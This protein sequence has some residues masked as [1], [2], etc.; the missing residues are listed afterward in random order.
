MTIPKKS[1]ASKTVTKTVTKAPKAES[2][3]NPSQAETASLTKLSR[4]GFPIVAIG[5]SAGGLEAFEIFFDAMPSN[6]GIGFILVAHLDPTH[7][8]LL[9]EL[10]Q[11]HTKMEVRQIQDGMKVLPDNVYVIPPNRDLTILNGSLQLM[12][13]T[14]PRGVNLPID[15]FFRSLAKDQ[16]PNATCI[17][18]SGTGTD[19][20]LGLRAIKGEVGMAMIQSEESAKYDG[21]PRSAISTGLADYILRPEEM[22]SHLIKYTRHVSLKSVPIIS[23][24][25]DKGANALQKIYI[26]LRE[27]T[28][29]DFS[30]YKKNTICRRI[31]R[32][33]SVH[34][35]DDIADYARYLQKS[36]RET[37][38]LFKELLIGVTNFFRDA[39]GFEALL[40]KHLM[41]LLQEKPENYTI[42]VW[43]PGCSSGEEAYSIAIILQ[44]CM[45]KLKSHFRVQIFGTDIDEDSIN[46]ARTGLYPESILADVSPE[47]LKR[48]FTEEKNG[49]YR[50][51]KSIREMLVFATQN[52]I[53]D[54]PFTKLDFLSCRNLLIYLGPELQQRLLPVF[55]YSLKNEGILFLGSSETVGKFT[56]LFVTLDQKWKIFKRKA[57]GELSYPSLTFPIIH[58]KNEMIYTPIPESVRK[59][60]AVSAL[61]LVETILQESNTPPCVIIDDSCNVVY[62]HGRTGRF[63]EPPEGKIS[64]NILEMARLGLKTDLAAA[65]RKVAVHKQE[66]ACRGLRIEGNDGG[67]YLNLSVK[68]IFEQSVMRGLMMVVFEETSK[69]TKKDQVKPL[70]R[71]I[72]D[73]KS[74]ETLKRELRHIKETLQTTIEEL[75]TSNEELKS[76]NEELQSTNE[77]LQSTNEEM[78]TS[79]EELQ[80]LNEESSTV[81]AELQRRIDELSETNDDMK[82]LLDRTEIA[83]LFLDT[84]LR[85][86]RFTPKTTEIIPLAGTDSGRP[87]MDFATSL[88]DANL[89][90]LGEQVLKDLAIKEAEVKSNDGRTYVIKIRPYRT[91]S[92]VIQGVVVTFEDITKR[93]LAEQKLKDL[94]RTSRAWLEHSPI[95][96]KVVDLDFNLQYMSGAGIEQLKI[97]DVRQFYG[98]A[99]P[100]SFYPESFRRTMTRNLEKAKEEGETITQESSL[101]DTEGNELW[102]ESTLV[103]VKNDEGLVDYII[104][105]SIDRTER[106]RAEEKLFQSE[107]SFRSV[108]GN[109]QVCV[110]RYDEQCKHI[111]QNA[112]GYKASGFTEEEFVGKTHRE[113][114]FEES[115]C[116]LWE[117]RIRSVFKTERPSSG[118]F[119]QQSKGVVATYDLRLFP[120]FDQ[121]KKVKSV[122]AISYETAK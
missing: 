86:R 16:G 77:E 118:V 70:K 121:N 85:I 35:I 47:R 59:A 109:M 26:I 31:E 74:A 90:G 8:S 79:K 60:E 69:S 33:M 19:G 55:H 76:T 23:P 67:L 104:V 10:L 66:V 21:M 11:K 25:E 2:Q 62:I 115:L 58:T 57:S 12:N 13:F 63:L 1:A 9:P 98:K 113:L 82:N 6:S 22:P 15:S 24:I 37:G 7:V 81:N 32:R 78:E 99:Y 64:V 61:Q 30:L 93:I 48:Y 46:I 107:E 87:I 80:S 88:I 84:E 106:K 53:K 68:P 41:K 101:F 38:I 36:D 42:R 95:C 116:A 83:T 91:S 97:D 112:A 14:Q 89:A 40:E 119:E 27:Q 110:M 75:E 54:P 50:V 44:E 71:K 39:A 73:E 94:E 45:E 96:T 92:N 114:G 120:E 18:L 105:V 5:A 111:Y 100:F 51:R 49:Q 20:T 52:V 3:P 108:A 117:E 34:Q 56:D 4:S 28:D 43:V 122:L 102:Y 17:I 72:E 29:H 103:P 65:I